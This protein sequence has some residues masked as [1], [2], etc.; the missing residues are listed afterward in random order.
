[1]GQKEKLL[2]RLRSHSRDFTFNEMVALLGYLGFVRSN[3]GATT[4]G[5]RV[6]F[7]HET[8]GAITMHR[9]HPGNEL[10]PYQIRQLIET[11]EGKGFL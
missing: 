6:R 3:K 5:L 11:L 4:S 1:M 10:K 7:T 8:C 9:P 2:A